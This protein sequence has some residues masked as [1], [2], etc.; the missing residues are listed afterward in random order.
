MRLQY[1]KHYKI[2]DNNIL[3][4]AIKFGCK[5]QTIKKFGGTWDTTISDESNI[6]HRG[7]DIDDIL[8][9]TITTIKEDPKYYDHIFIWDHDNHDSF[10]VYEYIIEPESIDDLQTFYNTHKNKD[11]F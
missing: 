6:E 1:I 9:T 3:E 11:I 2:E 5:L 7:L 10:N 8:L 4:L